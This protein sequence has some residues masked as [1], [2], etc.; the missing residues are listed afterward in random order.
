MREEAEGERLCERRSYRMAARGLYVI[1]GGVGIAMLFA[2]PSLQRARG[3]AAAELDRTL[4][5]ES[6]HYCEKWGML[7]GSAASLA[8]IRDLIRIREES[9]QRTRD[10]FAGGL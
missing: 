4:A 7:A 1:G 2:L 6:V 5:A 3:E 10:Q 8:C 9:E